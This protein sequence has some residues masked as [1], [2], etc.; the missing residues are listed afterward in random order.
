MR[1]F[2]RFGFALRHKI[3]FNP[4]TKIGSLLLWTHYD[5]SFVLQSLIANANASK[6]EAMVLLFRQGIAENHAIFPI[7]GIKDLLSILAATASM[8]QGKKYS[9]SNFENRT[10]LFEPVKTIGENQGMAFVK[11]RY[12]TPVGKLI[13][14]EI[15]ELESMTVE[16]L[17]NLGLTNLD[18]TEGLKDL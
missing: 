9:F 4:K 14:S 11:I 10:I 2:S 6:D 7:G 12:S 15:L 13:E 17:R 5:G 16:I 18:I 8:R 1:L 3:N